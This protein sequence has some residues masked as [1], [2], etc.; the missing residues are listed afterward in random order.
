MQLGEFIRRVDNVV[1][2]PWLLGLLLGT[3]VYLTIMLKGLPLFKLKQ[4]LGYAL[5]F[6]N[7]VKKQGSVSSFSALMTEL[8]ATIGTGNIVGV[9]TAMVLGGPGALFWM[10][11]SSIIGL[12]TK[13]VESTLAVKYRDK[14]SLQQLSGGPM[15]VMEHAFPYKRVGH[16]LAVSFSLFAVLASFGMGNM[17]QANSI[18]DALE[19]AFRI[20]NEKSG[21]FVALITILVVLGGIGMISRVTGILVPCMGIFYLLGCLAVIVSHWKNLPGAVAGIVTAAFCPSAAS[22]GLFGQICVSAFE[23]FRWGISRGIFSNEA[24]LGA[25]GISAAAADT[26]EPV[27]QGFISMT[28]V[29]FDTIVLCTATGLALAA[30]GVFTLREG[31]GAP[32]TG[33]TLVLEAFRSV[34]GDFGEQFM[35]ISMV[36][37][38][39]ATIIGW[40]YQ[41]EKAFEFLMRGEVKYNKYYRFV[42]ALIGFLGCMCPLEIIWDISDIC[43]GLMAVPNL[44]C[45]LVLSRPIC[46]EILSWV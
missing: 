8:A 17:V 10:I 11:I 9:S 24:G 20:P 35:G 27:K 14:N 45:L 29:F 16:I 43:N 26:K 34:F 37:F 36:L 39:F 42:Y 19:V 15:Y 18:A 28:G 3:G 33:I 30:S 2:G 7:R 6:D 5:G 40:A 22:G 25:A 21:L 38:A 44:I 31:S 1:W 32:V 4:A 41:G 46:K 13:L 12:A 23:S